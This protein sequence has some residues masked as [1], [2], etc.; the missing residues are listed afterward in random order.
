MH[1]TTWV[2]AAAIIGCPIGIVTLILLAR[3]QSAAA[4]TARREEIEDAVKNAVTP[5][6]DDRDYWRNRANQF[7]TELRN[8]NRNGAGT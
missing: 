1:L 4:A 7:E 6:K 5:I 3:G 8:R 2:A